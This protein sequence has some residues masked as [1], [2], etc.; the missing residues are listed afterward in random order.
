MN[1]TNGRVCASQDNNSISMAS[2]DSR[3]G[4]EYVDLILLDSICIPNLRDIFADTLG[5]TGK[6]GL[7]DAEGVAVDAEDAAIGWDTISY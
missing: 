3:T 5:F 4:E 6:D 7:V 1:V 2:D